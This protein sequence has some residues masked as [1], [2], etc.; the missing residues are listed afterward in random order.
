MAALGFWQCQPSLLCESLPHGGA[1]S[2]SIESTASGERTLAAA[3]TIKATAAGL[4]ASAGIVK[5][6]ACRVVAVSRM[7][8]CVIDD[9]CAAS[10]GVMVGV[11]DSCRGSSVGMV[12]A[13]SNLRRGSP[14]RMMKRVAD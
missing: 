9:S 3:G 10:I 11:A 1:A 7:M 14:C 5:T 12:I 8:Q 4:G 13:V 6:A 2:R